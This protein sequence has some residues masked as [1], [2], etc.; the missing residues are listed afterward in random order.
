[1]HT[2]LDELVDQMV[3]GL[4][5]NGEREGNEDIGSVD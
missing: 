2:L 3:L 1:M 5:G 4:I